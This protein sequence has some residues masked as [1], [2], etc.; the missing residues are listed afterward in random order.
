V[1]DKWVIVDNDQELGPFD[2]KGPPVFSP[3]SRHIAYE[4]KKGDY[5]YVY[6]DNKKSEWAVSYYDKPAFNNNSNK[7][8]LFE[9]TKDESTFRLTVSD[10]SFSHLTTRSLKTSEKFI[11]PDKTRIAVVDKSGDFKK[12]ID[13]TF[14]D[15][16]IVHSS[17]LYNSISNLTF[18]DDGS[19]LAY[20][21]KKDGKSFMVLNGKEEQIPAGE[22]PWAPVIRPDSKSAGIIIV[23]SKGAFYHQV[24]CENKIRVNLYKECADLTYSTDG[25]S[26]AYVAIKNEHFLIVTNGKEGPVFDRVISPHFSPDGK[27]LVY[28]ARQ[29]GKRFV[30]VADANGTII[31][32]HPSYERVFETIF[33]EDGK[34]VAYGVKDGNQ[35]WWKVEKL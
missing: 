23:G 6:V 24:F 2:D 12:V 22:Y 8:M 26:H 33:T 4:I 34:S 32:K 9:N 13:F 11:S 16:S 25:S 18:S 27:Y 28:R 21:A 3:D 10:I 17:Q 29:D 14:N 19:V 20:I 30:I 15:P 1:G 5:W 35:L 7:V 31:K